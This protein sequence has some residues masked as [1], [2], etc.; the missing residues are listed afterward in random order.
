MGIRV[1]VA[2]DDSAIR[3][4]LRFSFSFE[5]DRYDLCFAADGREAI[6]LCRELRPD[7]LVTDSLLP[8][9]TGEE[10]VK[11]CRDL[12]MTVIS[13]SGMAGKAAWADH[14]VVKG[15]PDALEKLRSLID[16][17]RVRRVEE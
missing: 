5:S 2:E 11:A 8:F 16:A 12:G 7:V 9:L 14:A 6:E 10:V 15:D 17:E 3:E 13:F 1:V 4:M